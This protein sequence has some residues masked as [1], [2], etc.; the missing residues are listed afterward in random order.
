VAWRY[1]EARDAGASLP[2]RLAGLWRHWALLRRMAE[3]DL[4]QRYVGSGLGLAWAAIHPLLLIT[5]YALIF[6]FI[7][8]GRLRPDAPPAEYALYV[9]T[10][11]LPWASVSEVA[12]RSV[13]VMAEHRGLVKFVVF[14][15]QILPLTSVLVVGLSQAVGL[16]ALLV[17]TALVRG[18]DTSLLLLIVILPLQA[19]LLAGIAWLLGAI[20]AVARDVRDVVQILLTVGMFVT[21]IFFLER[22]LPAALRFAVALNPITHLVRLYRSAFLGGGLQDTLS[23]VVVAALALALVAIG[24]S[25]FERVRLFL[26]DLL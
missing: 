25:L 19:V 8:R 15:L 5:A 26:S 3:R 12:T 18:L 6:T 23:L 24:F 1:A 9:L 10:G 14:P 2:V 11:L 7:F 13:Q 17:L 20:G 21:P 22:D 16:V 4:R